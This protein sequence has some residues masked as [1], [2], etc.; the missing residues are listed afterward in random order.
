MS[1]IFRSLVIRCHR[2]SDFNSPVSIVSGSFSIEVK[3]SM[4]C[5]IV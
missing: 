3:G 1:L 4:S 2:V 5:L